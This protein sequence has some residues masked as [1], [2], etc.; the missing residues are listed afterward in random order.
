MT[1]RPHACGLLGAELAGAVL[2]QVNGSGSSGGGGGGGG[3]LAE[4]L[5]VEPDGGGSSNSGISTAPQGPIDVI[6]KPHGIRMAVDT[7]MSVATLK[8]RARKSSRVQLQVARCNQCRRTQ[9]CRRRSGW[10]RISLSSCYA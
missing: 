8:V 7:E 6:I 4:A 3:A 10:Y 9:S 5:L 1:R 2:V